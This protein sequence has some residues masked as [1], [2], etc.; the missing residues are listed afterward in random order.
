MKIN[1]KILAIKKKKKFIKI[2]K[3]NKKN[4]INKLII[5]NG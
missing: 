4:Y 5:E 1:K 3:N 2:L